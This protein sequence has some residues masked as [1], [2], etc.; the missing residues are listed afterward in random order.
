[1]SFFDMGPLANPL[2]VTFTFHIF[3]TLLSHFHNIQAIAL[4]EMHDLN[5]SPLYSRDDPD[6]VINATYYLDDFTDCEKMNPLWPQAIKDGFAE[7]IKIIG[8]TS[9]RDPD[10]NGESFGYPEFKW[11][12]AAA[13]EYVTH[14]TSNYYFLDCH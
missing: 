2:A 8:G 1:M 9:I 12:S 13:I 11:T 5:T 6:P 7:A 14:S 10:G 3:L 4:P